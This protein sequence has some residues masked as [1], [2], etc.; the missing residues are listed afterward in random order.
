M[1][2]SLTLHYINGVARGG[3]AVPV[4]MSASLARATMSMHDK[5]IDWMK[6]HSQRIWDTSEIHK[7][8]NAHDAQLVNPTSLS[9]GVGTGHGQNNSRQPL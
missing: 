8:A 3:N 9:G 1:H 4:Q 5:D 7:Q 2:Y 6:R